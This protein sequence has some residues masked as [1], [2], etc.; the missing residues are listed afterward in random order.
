MAD[1]MEHID[2]AGNFTESFKENLGEFAG[3]AHADS[4]AFDS[5]SNVGT[6]VKAY[7]DTKSAYGKKLEN[8]IRKPAENATTEEK[9]EYRKTLANEMGA[10][11][12]VDGYELPRPENLPEGINFSDET[13]A[14]FKELF[15][16]EGVSV[17][18][19]RRLSDKLYEVQLKAFQDRVDAEQREFQAAC[20][21]LDK[22]WSG[23]AAIE[24]NRI[25][26]KALMQFADDDLKNFVKES[27]IYEDPNNHQKWLELGFNPPQ[28]RIWHNIGVATKSSEAITNEGAATT[29]DDSPEAA[30]KKLY[31]HPSSQELL[32]STGGK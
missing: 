32:R 1:I 31:P 17:D 6:L 8:M 10:P 5:I 23:D 25:A 29:K 3:E 18:T 20:V 30:F 12:S 21:E 11:E 28:R 26:F 4:K 2:E 9:S 13:E 7:A 15:F 27:K 22:D 19:A 14:V 24:N 16:E